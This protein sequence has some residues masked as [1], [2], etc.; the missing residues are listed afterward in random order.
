MAQV[1]FLK[2]VNVGGHKT[3]KPS[4]LAMQLKQLDVTSIGAAGTFVIRK[5]ISQSALKAQ[6]LRRLPFDAELIICP[7]KDI[8]KLVESKPFAKH[9][10]LKDVAA[11]VTILAKPVA[12][13]PRLPI[14]QPIGDQWQVKVLAITGR[15]VLSL[16]RRIAK[17]LIYPNEVVERAFEVSA[18]TR[19][20]NT[21]EAIGRAF[22]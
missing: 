8:V 22:D 19:N 4:E 11:Y 6:V 17:R 21:I 10:P 5:N 1:L 15:F 3:F 16:H 20:W 13:K 14:T 12:V 7:G 9:E 2:G 18:T